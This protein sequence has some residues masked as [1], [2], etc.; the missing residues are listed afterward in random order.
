M[1]LDSSKMS[2]KDPKDEALYQLTACEVRAGQKWKHYKTG[3]IYTIV[4]TGIG[5][6]T[7]SPVVVYV[8]REGVVWVRSLAT[9]ISDNDEGKPRF[10]L[11]EDE[12][13]SECGE[14]TQ[15]FPKN[16][17]FEALDNDVHWR[18]DG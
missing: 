2:P 3:G 8:D 16:Y 11:L 15:P 12:T 1:I 14:Q 10:M 13:R 6:A 7:L 18:I 17:G 5:E 9:F 4:A